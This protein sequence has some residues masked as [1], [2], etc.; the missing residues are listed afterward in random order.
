[1]MLTDINAYNVVMASS[2]TKLM[3]G[4][5]DVLMVTIL[6][7]KETA[8]YVVPRGMWFVKSMNKCVTFVTLQ[9]G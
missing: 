1:M 9:Q 6:T 7:R 8:A 5:L 4:A 3:A 2:T